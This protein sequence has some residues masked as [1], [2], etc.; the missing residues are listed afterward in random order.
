M[1][2]AGSSAAPVCSHLS[3]SSSRQHVYLRRD[4]RVRQRH[5]RQF[6]DLA[7]SN[8]SAGR[9]PV[10]R[11]KLHYRRPPRHSVATPVTIS[12]SIQLYGSC[13]FTGESPNRYRTIV[14]G[15]PAFS[16]VSNEASVKLAGFTILANDATAGNA[17]IAMVVDGTI[18]SLDQTVV[19]S[20]AGGAGSPG[21]K[22]ANGKGGIHGNNAT[23][24]QFGGDG[25]PAVACADPGHTI[26]G[27]GGAG[28]PYQVVDSTGGLTHTTCT[29]ANSSIAQ[30]GGDAPGA[31]GGKGGPTEALD[32]IAWEASPV[33]LI[34]LTASRGILAL[35]D[36]RVLPGELPALTL[37]GNFAI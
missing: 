33:T 24:P 2:L 26:S 8:T 1:P 11:A 22:G 27:Y 14:R 21:V 7:V 10:Q 6:G 31:A 17:S 4:H 18:L 23:V 9:K 5:L 28:A 35:W 15:L 32:A 37:S 34:R 20:G 30:K 19:V 29:P 36:H 3:F 13:S 12:S 16:I 25:G